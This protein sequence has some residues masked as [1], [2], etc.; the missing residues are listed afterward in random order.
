MARECRINFTWDNEACVWIA[1]SDDVFGLIL[2]HDS[3]D[4]L[5]ERVRLAVPELLALEG[6]L[7]DDISLDYGMLRKERL[8]L[9][10]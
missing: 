3:L 1:T 10:G 4:A 8:A 5:V 7:S 6:T 2:E 9:S